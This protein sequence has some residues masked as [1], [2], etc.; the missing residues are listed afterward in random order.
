MGSLLAQREA[1]PPSALSEPAC[2]ANPIGLLI[3]CHRIVRADGELGN[4][5]SGIER[6]KWLLTHE[7]GYAATLA[8]IASDSA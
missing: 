1:R 7:R 5:G 4:Y 3:P 8:A 2:G 6:K